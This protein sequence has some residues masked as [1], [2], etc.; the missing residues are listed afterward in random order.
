MANSKG[1]ISIA[2]AY[3]T[4]GIKMAILRGITS[5]EHGMMM[6]DEYIEM[7][8][9]VGTDDGTYNNSHRKRQKNLRRNMGIST[10]RNDCCPQR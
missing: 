7:L 6:V 4:D 2:H 3:V 10:L 1:R 5:I 8:V 9:A